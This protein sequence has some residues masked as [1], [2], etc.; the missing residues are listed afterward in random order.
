MTAKK[1]TP[2][3]EY[4]FY[5]QPENQ[6]PQGPARRRSKLTELVPVR[7]PPETL[8]E[9]RR[10]SRRG[11][12]FGL[13]LDPPCRRARARAEPLSRVSRFVSAPLDDEDL[14]ADTEADELTTDRAY[15]LHQPDEHIR[16]R[17]QRSGLVRLITRR[18][19][20]QIP[21]PPPR[22][23][24]QRPFPLSGR[25]SLVTTVSPGE[26]DRLVTTSLRRRRL[27]AKALVTAWVRSL[28]DCELLDLRVVNPKVIERGF[29]IRPRNCEMLERAPRTSTEV[30][31]CR[32]VVVRRSRR[33][34]RSTSLD[35]TP[36]QVRAESNARASTGVRPTS[37]GARSMFAGMRAPGPSCGGSYGRSLRYRPGDCLPPRPPSALV[38]DT[39]ES[40]R[41]ADASTCSGNV[42]KWEAGRSRALQPASGGTTTCLDR[43]PL[44]R[45]VRTIA[46]KK[47][48]AKPVNTRRPRGAPRSL[49]L[50]TARDLFAKQDYR[51]I[52]TKEI[53]ERADV[54]EH[55]LFRNFGS[56][57]ALFKEAM[58]VPFLSLVDDLTSKWETLAPGLDSAEAV[59][60][61]FLGS[62]YDAVP[63]EPWIGHDALDRRGP[64][65]GGACRNR[66][67]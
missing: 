27:Q 29:E 63:R 5:A 37:L 49:L 55:L 46:T 40:G 50:E 35:L 60:R 23:A 67:R 38:T 16:C 42:R 10:A 6:E 51:S 62:L 24:G 53:A 19:R 52:T 21:P 25:A 32:A 48:V 1:M 8:A 47:P 43:P 33:P 17:R 15:D 54:L 64:H 44:Q 39:L 31:W 14:Q 22:S 20:V 4:D 65:A 9:V 36:K 26:G 12:P 28:P 59:A 30:H 66:Y 11:R 61:D 57:A 34:P 56:K 45:E 2:D 41:V 13:E 18:S 3:E 7:F 58:V